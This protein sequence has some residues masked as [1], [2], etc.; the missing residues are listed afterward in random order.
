MVQRTLRVVMRWLAWCFAALV[1]YA[2]M[3]I[4]IAAL[5]RHQPL[6]PGFAIAL[7]VY[8]VMTGLVLAFAGLCLV[9]IPY[10]YVVWAAPERRFWGESMAWQTGI[11]RGLAI[12]AVAGVVL[13]LTWHAGR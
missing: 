4:V 9:V 5:I 10:A 2:L 3:V 13:A 11:W 12:G 7:F 6:T 1:G 8:N